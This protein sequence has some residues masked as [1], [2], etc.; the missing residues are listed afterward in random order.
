MFEILGLYCIPESIIEVIRV[1]YTNTSST[2]MTPDGE[3]EPIYIM[4]GIFQGDTLAPFLFIMVLDYALRNLLDPNHTKGF[5]LHPRKSY[6]HPAVH[7]TDADLQMILH[8][9]VTLLKM[10]KH[11]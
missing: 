2:I 9:Y 1:L 5:Q 7:F 8:Q 11:F 10:L 4:A 6:R 3:T